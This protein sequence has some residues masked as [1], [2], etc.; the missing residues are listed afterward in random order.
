[1]DID[2]HVWITTTAV[3]SM[4]QAN[5]T[6]AQQE[7]KKITRDLSHVEGDRSRDTR[8]GNNRQRTRGTYR[9]TWRQRINALTVAKP[10]QRRGHYRYICVSQKEDIYNETKNG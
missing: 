10:L 3:P 4:D 6:C 2:C 8:Q 9:S 5:E 1:M 7:L